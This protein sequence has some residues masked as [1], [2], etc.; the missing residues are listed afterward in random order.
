MSR[1]HVT[2][3]TLDTQWWDRAHYHPLVRADGR[4]WA[5]TWLKRNWEYQ[6]AVEKMRAHGDV[7]PLGRA[8]TCLNT[9]NL[10][11]LFHQG[12]LF[13]RAALAM[14][15]WTKCCSGDQIWTRPCSQSQQNRYPVGTQMP[16]T[17]PIAPAAPI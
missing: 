9:P 2:A 12:Y 14:T 16:L 5:W 10:H 11:R 6:A 7:V 4:K 3:E 8:S 15:T 17:S 13:M 1:W